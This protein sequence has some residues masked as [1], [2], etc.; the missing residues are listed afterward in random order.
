MNGQ[1]VSQHMIYQVDAERVEALKSIRHKVQQVCGQCI[2][3]KVR[4]ETI[5][6]H[7]YEGMIVNI[8]NGHLYLSIPQPPM[9]RAFFN[10]FQ[11][12][13]YNNVILPLVLYE[14]LVISLLST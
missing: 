6:G 10:P 5:D 1:P 14:L 13:Y 8:S 11:S 12:V 3:R 9:Q 2:H 4:V 7:I